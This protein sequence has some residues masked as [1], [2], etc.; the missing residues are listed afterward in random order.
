MSAAA[1]VSAVLPPSPAATVPP[2]SPS[3]WLHGCWT[4]EG[5]QGPLSLG[6]PRRKPSQ[7]SLVSIHSCR[8]GPRL[9][10]QQPWPAAR[11][12]SSLFSQKVVL[13]GTSPG[14]WLSE[15]PE[16]L[17]LLITCSVPPSVYLLWLLLPLPGAGGGLGLGLGRLR[18][19]AGL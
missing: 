19:G 9:Y 4:W 13:L 17:P 10:G 11:L 5:E 14:P 12:C 8:N 2:S 16:Y 18:G 7:Q 1:S 6:L 3:R 15:D